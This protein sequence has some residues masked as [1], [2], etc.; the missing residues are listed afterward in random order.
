MC[1]PFYDIKNHSI[2]L[3][4]SF[5]IRSA[6]ATGCQ[7]LHTHQHTHT[8]NKWTICCK[9]K[10]YLMVATS[11]LSSISVDSS[12][13]WWDIVHTNN[14]RLFEFIINEEE[15]CISSA[16]FFLCLHLVFDVFFCFSFLFTKVLVCLILMWI[17]LKSLLHVLFPFNSFFAAEILAT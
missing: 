7:F 3:E 6:H 4:F 17:L 13:N 10:C 16:L 12:Q 9:E 1:A 8:V 5:A 11:S 15:K 2:L 14:L